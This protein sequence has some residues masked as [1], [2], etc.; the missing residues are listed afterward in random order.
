MRAI[1]QRVSRASVRVDGSDVADIGEGMVVF[2]G[3]G[4]EDS[5]QDSTYLAK[6]ISGLR[7][8]EDCSEKMNLDITAGKGSILV[9]SQFTLYGDCRKGRRPS[10]ENA[11]SG[12]FAKNLY[13]IF[14]AELVESGV[15]VRTGIFGAHMDVS[16]VNSGPVSL[17]L[18]SSKIF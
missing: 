8:F 16:L 18:D 5:E 10:Y 3:V 9:I 11:A 4:K 6:K 12:D 14:V 13:E 7:I 1:V 15:S 2:L 17:L